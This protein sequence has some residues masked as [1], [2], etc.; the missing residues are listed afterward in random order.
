MIGFRFV[1]LGAL[2][3]ATAVAGALVLGTAPSGAVAAPAT[4]MPRCDHALYPYAKFIA[5]TAEDAAASATGDPGAPP[6]QPA[7]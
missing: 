7:G 5:M 3:P 1:A 4:C 2:L 6:Q